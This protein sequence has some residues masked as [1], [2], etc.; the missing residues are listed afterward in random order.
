MQLEAINNRTLDERT[1]DMFMNEL[2]KHP[3]QK[4]HPL[5][6]KQIERFE[7]ELE[8]SNTS[9]AQEK[10][11]A[12]KAFKERIVVLAGEVGSYK[13][14]NAPQYKNAIQMLQGRLVQK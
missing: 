9:W 7:Y 13:L 14:I 1:A 2:K 12:L 5:V 4:D 11:S 6:Q 10:L 8:L 3:S